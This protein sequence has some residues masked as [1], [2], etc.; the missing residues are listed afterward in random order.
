MV[1]RPDYD[2]AKAYALARLES[3]LPSFLSYHSLYHTRDD[4]LPAA[5]RLALFE[6]IGTGDLLLLQTAVLYHDIGFTIQ[7][8]NH[9]SLSAQIAAEIL[10]SF[11]YLPDEIQ[12]IQGMILVTKLFTPPQ[13]LLEAIMVDAD[14]DVLG[15][16]DF[17]KRNLDLRTE[18]TRLGRNQTDGQWYSQQLR[19]MKTHRYR[20]ISAQAMRNPLKTHHMKTLAGLLMASM[21][22]PSEKRRE[23]L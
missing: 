4:V 18:I 7:V 10:P 15:R 5:E 16:E 1:S 6:G 2:H 9:E 21:N 23:F 11:G 14:L 13:T 17:F 19:F 20:T 8:D 22:S 3:Q 12:K